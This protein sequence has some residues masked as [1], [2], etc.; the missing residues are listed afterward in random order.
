MTKWIVMHSPARQLVIKNMI[1]QQGFDFDVGPW[2]V[3]NEDN[4]LHIHSAHH[5]EERA[6]K[7]CAEKNAKSY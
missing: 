3:V 4:T 2:L 7:E 6:V 5:T 1:K